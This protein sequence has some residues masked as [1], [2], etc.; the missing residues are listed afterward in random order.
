MG[1]VPRSGPRGSHF[2]AGCQLMKARVGSSLFAACRIRGGHTGV[3]PE[4]KSCVATKAPHGA[5]HELPFREHPECMAPETAPQ[6][7]TP[8]AQVP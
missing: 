4:T 6:T 2:R 1:D 3:A 5:I 7:Q 8:D